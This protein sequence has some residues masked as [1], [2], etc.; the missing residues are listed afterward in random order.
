MTHTRAASGSSAPR[1]T[2]EDAE[3]AEVIPEDLCVLSGLCGA[4]SDGGRIG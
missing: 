3:D 4:V 2:A 1:C